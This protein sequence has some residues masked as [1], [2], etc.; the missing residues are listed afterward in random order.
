MV[1]RAAAPKGTMSCRTQGD[2]CRIGFESTIAPRNNL[3]NRH[4]QGHP[5]GQTDRKH[6]QT[7]SYKGRKTDRLPK[8]VSQTERDETEKDGDFDERGRTRLMEICFKAGIRA[9]RLNRRK[10]EDT[11]ISLT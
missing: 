1:S 4:V 2:L 7:V 5:A 10:K 11:K 6:K 9:K 8:T 3:E